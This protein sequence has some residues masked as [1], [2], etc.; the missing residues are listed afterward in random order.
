MRETQSYKAAQD[1]R[2]GLRKLPQDRKRPTERQKKKKKKKL[3]NRDESG[4]RLSNSFAFIFRVV[5][6]SLLILANVNSCL[7]SIGL[8]V[9]FKNILMRG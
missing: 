3:T 6:S 8:G 7:K 1:P 9:I 2:R 4:S 5:R